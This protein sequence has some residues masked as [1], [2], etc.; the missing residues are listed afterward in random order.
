MKEGYGKERKKGKGV[1]GR[2]ERKSGLSNRK[3]EERGEGKGG[4]TDDAI[5]VFVV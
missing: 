4:E 2:R 5:R 3:L 1:G